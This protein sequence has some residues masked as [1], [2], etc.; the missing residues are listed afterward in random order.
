MNNFSNLTGVK[1]WWQQSP[2]KLGGLSNSCNLH[3]FKIVTMCN[4]LI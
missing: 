1:L 2:M 4:A 3:S